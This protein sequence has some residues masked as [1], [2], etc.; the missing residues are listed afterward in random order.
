MVVTLSPSHL[1]QCFQ[2]IFQFKKR[3]L[4]VCFIFLSIMFFP[5]IE[6]LG[7]KN[8][9]C[10]LLFFTSQFKLLNTVIYFVEIK[11]HRETQMF[12]FVY[13]L[14][15]LSEYKWVVD[16]LYDCCFYQAC[17]SPFFIDSVS[18]FHVFLKV[19]DHWCC[20]FSKLF[21]VANDSCF[22]L[23]IKVLI[24]CI[25]LICRMAMLETSVKMLFFS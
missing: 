17:F 15:L 10:I 8:F 21:F 20:S 24:Y 19:S 11:G 7:M 9:T 4:S 1:V 18:F 16:I 12:Y 22:H 6:S 5:D 3:K 25:M 13:P 23:L 14:I 2:F